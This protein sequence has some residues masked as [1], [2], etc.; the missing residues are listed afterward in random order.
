MNARAL[1]LLPVLGFAAGFAFGWFDAPR[2]AISDAISPAPESSKLTPTFNGAGSNTAAS[3]GGGEASAN[4]AAPAT[5]SDAL[6][7][8]S[9]L[10]RRYA[11]RQFY[12]RLGPADFPRVLAELENWRGLLDTQAIVLLFRSWVLVAPAEAIRRAG[13]LSDEAG[14]ADIVNASMR[15]WAR[16]EPAA[17]RR[18]AET[19]PEPF[20]MT[21][22]AY[23]ESLAALQ[24]PAQSPAEALPKLLAAPNAM[25]NA[26][27]I[28]RLFSDWA[29]SDPAA[30]M[31]EAA[32]LDASL[33]GFVLPNLVADWTRKDPDAVARWLAAF[34]AGDSL[35]E[36]LRLQHAESLAEIAPAAAVQYAQGLPDSAG[37]T[38]V[39]ASAATEWLARDP[40]AAIAF[41]GQQAQGAKVLEFEAFF[42]AW[43]QTEPE[44]AAHAFAEQLPAERTRDPNRPLLAWVFDP[45]FKKDP[46]AAGNFAVAEL[47]PDDRREVLRSLAWSWCAGDATAAGKWAAALSESEGKNRAML[48][49]AHVWAKH[50][51]T[52][53]TDWLDSLPAGPAKD[54]AV[55]GFAETSF[56]TDP[57]GALAWLRSGVSEA[58]RIERVSRVWGWWAGD[59]PQAARAWLTTT[60]ALNPAERA[61]LEQ[62]PKAK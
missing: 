49:V 35:R 30:A 32:K 27:K 15:A 18:F 59:Y 6:K 4:M 23:I 28:R 34:P 53:A 38:R 42:R 52:Q 58:Q 29:G 1:W 31:Q 48:Q 11:L 44:R 55:D 43:S 25:Q 61:A 50:D 8:P 22:V 62:S 45:W 56:N 9:V 3:V 54:A 14:R 37:R 36:T 13:E 39:L 24:A 17:A 46:A 26:G 33:R 41:V 40:E 5:L 19:M 7:F 2:A 16:K 60:T 51:A 21:S 10:H 47:R 12:G 20:R 57:D